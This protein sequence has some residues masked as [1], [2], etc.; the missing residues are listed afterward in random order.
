[1][2][3][4]TTKNVYESIKACPGQK[5][6]PGIRRCIYFVS[7]Y[8]VVTWPKLPKLGDEEVTKMESLSQLK[9]DFVLAA[10]KFFRSIELKDKASNVT[11]ETVGNSGSKLFTNKANAIVV[12]MPDE[13]KGFIRQAIDDKLIVVYQQRDGKFCVLGN[14]DFPCETSGSGDTGSDPTNGDMTSTIALESYDECPVPTYTGKLPLS[15]T[16]YLDCAD[17]LVKKTAEV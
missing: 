11:F 6:V 8:S 5:T 2:K 4:C 15:A 13:V 3:E 1:M 10:E 7:M 9:G 12:G 17:G 16:E 14:E